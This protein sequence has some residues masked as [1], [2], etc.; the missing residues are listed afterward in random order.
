MTDLE[1]HPFGR[2]NLDYVEYLYGNFRQNPN[3]VDARW[4]AFFRH[5]EAKAGPL[6]ALSPDEEPTGTYDRNP[7]IDE[8]PIIHR[9][10]D[11]HT[12][13]IA[14]HV[15]EALSRIVLFK[16]LPEGARRRLAQITHE[17]VFPAAHMVSAAGQPVNDMFFILEGQVALMKNERQIAELGPGEMIGELAVF[18]KKPRSAGIVTKTS[19]TMLHIPRA[20][21][22]GMLHRD[23]ELTLALLK[24]LSVRLRDAGTRQERVDQLV[25]AYR[26][27]GHVTAK[28]DPLGLNQGEHHELDLE[29]YG[30][31]PADLSSRF[32]VKLG[33]ETARRSL[34]DILSRLKKIYCQHVGAQYRHID[35]PEIQE[36][37]RLRLENQ[38]G[39]Y[40]MVR[41]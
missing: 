29:Y 19:C 1:P 20:E 27:M 17:V 18:D 36:W 34:G 40:R 30:L 15:L 11:S 7:S 31:G 32:S 35:N 25:R 24:D 37:I 22:F 9:A 39:N 28:L 5:E 13:E 10:E 8:H 14:P 12:R 6:E 2:Q 26:E 38:G 21:L 33:E 41:E 3:S 4:Q 23:N 16:N